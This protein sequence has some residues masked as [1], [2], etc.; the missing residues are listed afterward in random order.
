MHKTSL[1]ILLVIFFSSAFAVEKT[2]NCAPEE[3][4]RLKIENYTFKADRKIHA[5][6]DH[7]KFI[8]LQQEFKR[9]QDVTLACLSCH[10]ERHEEVM[11][12]NHF[13][14]DRQE[15]I[16]NHGQVS[17]G[18][19]N[20]L[21]NFCVGIGSNEAMCTK[22]HAGYGWVDTT[23]NFQAKENIDCLVCHDKTGTYEK[24]NGGM[25]TTKTDLNLVA[26]NVGLS[27]AENCGSC[28]FVGGGGN[29]V[30]HGDLEKAMLNSDRNLDVHMAKEGEDMSCTDCHV[31]ENHN[32]TGKLY[33]L[34]SENSDRVSCE[35]CHTQAPHSKKILNRHTDRVACQTCHIPTYAKA[36]PTKIYWDW[37]TAGKR[38][39]NGGMIETKDSLGN[40]IYFSKK[41]SFV[42]GKNIEP[43]YR[44]FNGLAGHHLITDQIDTIPVQINT[45][46]GSYGDKGEN[47][48]SLA[49]SKIWPVKIM[50]GKQPYDLKY[51]TLLQ[52]K[53]VGPKGSGAFWADFDW[54]E[55][56]AKGSAYVHQPFSGEYGF[57]ETEMYWPL[58][59]QVAPASESL[60]CT[61]CHARG[62][63]SRIS[64]LSGFYLPGRDH[65]YWADLLGILLVGSTFLG[66]LIHGGLR[67][68]FN[69]NTEN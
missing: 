39:E 35:Q 21:N 8:I 26:Q 54:A 15:E 28:H 27:S 1:I 18:K 45:L 34:S 40:V 64:Q 50:R 37:S 16:L 20:I 29:N 12:N 43:E 62:E 22:C 25:P 65:F 30:K 19:K 3:S 5:P 52:P 59:H 46:D 53:V 38:T 31:T 61:A 4:S 13:S 68:F 41:G 48:R 44:W 66:V 36:N 14:W 60:S 24:G 63:D 42:W 6:G 7:Q 17:V 10:T 57:V 69:K 11:I 51:N 23:F 56:L 67:V 33:A 32:I 47:T 55:S 2:G 49:P 9:P 58:N